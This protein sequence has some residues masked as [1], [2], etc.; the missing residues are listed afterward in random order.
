VP[1]NVEM[2]AVA[3]TSEILC[4][5]MKAKDDAAYSV[6]TIPASPGYFFH[7]RPHIQPGD[8]VIVYMVGLSLL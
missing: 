1:K 7:S 8:I 4:K 5:D 3:S 6:G 2:A